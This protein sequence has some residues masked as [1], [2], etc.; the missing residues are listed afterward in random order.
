MDVDGVVADLVGALCLELKK[1][2]YRRHPKE[3]TH[4]HFEQCITPKENKIIRLAMEQPGFVRDMP[5]YPGAK[6]FLRRLRAIG[7]VVA[8]T[9]PYEKGPTWAYERTRW[10]GRHVDAIVQTPRKDLVPG[11]VFIEDSHDNLLIWAQ[12]NVGYPILMAR[13]WNSNTFDFTYETSYQD[14]L[15]DLEVRFDRLFP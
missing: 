3:F 7:E 11:D 9:R 8:L 10:L 13:P 5:W 12:R 14:I 6:R 15:N 1:R 2:G 4:Y